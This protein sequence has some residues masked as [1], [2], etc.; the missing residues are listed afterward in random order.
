MSVICPTLELCAECRALVFPGNQRWVRLSLHELLLMP[1]CEHCKAAHM[2][3][4]RVHTI[5]I[6]GPER[7]P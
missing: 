1:L 5:L 6:T 2:E 7:R 3:F 4:M